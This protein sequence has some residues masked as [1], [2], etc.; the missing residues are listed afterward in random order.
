M[1]RVEQIDLER[2]QPSGRDRRVVW[3]LMTRGLM[4][5]NSW[6]GALEVVSDKIPDNQRLLKWKI[7]CSPVQSDDQRHPTL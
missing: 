3:G 2:M 6:R 4:M 5:G 7:M 1:F